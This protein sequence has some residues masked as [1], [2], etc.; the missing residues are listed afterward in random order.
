MPLPPPVLTDQQRAEFIRRSLFASELL[1]LA[2]VRCRG[3]CRH[4]SPEECQAENQLLFPYRGV[5]VRHHRGDDGVVDAH[6]VLFAAAG[7]VHRISHPVGGGDACLALTLSADALESLA[8]ADGR[9]P[10]SRQTV[11]VALH[12]ERA[13]LQR[14]VVGGRI[15]ALEIESRALA[16]ALAAF[17]APAAPAIRRHRP[18]LALVER[19]RLYLAARRDRRVGLAEV[20]RAVGASPVYLTQVFARI[21][22]QPL[23]RYH[24]HLRLAE[25][26]ARLPEAADLAALAA[27]LGFASQSQL[28]NLFR[29]AYGLPPRRFLGAD[30]RA[31]LK[32]RQAGERRH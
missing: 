13:R 31:E 18:T 2:D 1:E 28:S 27:D 20:G 14:D 15:D 9:R 30:E 16:L 29:R 21:E 23:Y 8:R 6:Q 3:L 10:P 4:A 22:G 17:E 12:A 7:D 32:I 5:F 25:A 26:A 19:T 11:P 24:L